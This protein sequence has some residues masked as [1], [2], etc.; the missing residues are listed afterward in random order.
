MN[1][2]LSNHTVGAQ[3][4]VHDEEDGVEVR[5]QRFFDAEASAPIIMVDVL[6]DGDDDDRKRQISLIIIDEEEDE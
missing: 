1:L 6:V 4:L 3:V 5:V 2:R